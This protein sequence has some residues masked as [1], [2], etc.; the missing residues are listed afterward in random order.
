MMPPRDRSLPTV[1]ITLDEVRRIGHLA[2]LRLDDRELDSLRVELDRI[3]EYIDKLKQLNTEG[4]EPAV[5]ITSGQ[6]SSLRPDEPRPT[7][8]TD[9]ALVNAPESAAGHFKVPKIIT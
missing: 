8:P 1:K 9:E 3:L 2:H 5:A 4:V 6:P 7:L